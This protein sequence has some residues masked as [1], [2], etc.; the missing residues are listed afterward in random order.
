[1]SAPLNVNSGVGIMASDL[2]AP[3]QN[4]SRQTME[5]LVTATLAV[6][7]DRGLDGVTIPEIAARAE[8]S[9]GSVYR[10]FIDKD[11]LVRTAFLQLLE[12]SQAANATALPQDLFEGRSLEEALLALSRALVAQHRGRTGVMKALD[13]YL[14][15]QRD[16]DFR[17]RAL[18]LIQANMQRLSMTL[19]PFRREISA[20]D[21]DR[22]ITFALLSGVTLIEAQHLHTP[23]LWRRLLPL[24]EDELAVEVAKA[25]GAYLTRRD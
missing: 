1:M 13:R 6:I 21:P 18:D 16:D 11:A 19:R 8:L 20:Q 14:E 2:R 10:R 22:A 7:E 24:D 5:R 3:Q 4:R 17:R 12:A 25:M 23:L 9:T 15:E